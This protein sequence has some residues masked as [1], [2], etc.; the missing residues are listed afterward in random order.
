MCV[1]PYSIGCIP[2]VALAV[3][4]VVF[5]VSALYRC[6]MLFKARNHPL[7]VVTC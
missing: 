7:C 2:I 4:L 6:K 1:V 5:V 3:A